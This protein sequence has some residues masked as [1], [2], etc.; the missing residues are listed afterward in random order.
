MH[1]PPLSPIIRSLLILS[2]VG[3]IA[4]V[5]E[6]QM[7]QYGM[8]RYFWDQDMY[9]EVILQFVCFQ[10]L[11]GGVFHFLSNALFLVLFGVSMERHIG[12]RQM[13]WFFVFSNVFVGVLLL[14]GDIPTI[15]M[16]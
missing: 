16:S 8:H 1:F 11:H 3:T 6:P 14:A 9:L 2:L 10:F 12:S 15:G 4:I 7:A 13:L 5:V